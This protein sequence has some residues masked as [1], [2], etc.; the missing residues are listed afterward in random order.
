[1]FDPVLPT[2]RSHPNTI[3]EDDGGDVHCEKRGV[4]CP[5]N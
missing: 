4:R 2:E 1:V 5:G 3:Y